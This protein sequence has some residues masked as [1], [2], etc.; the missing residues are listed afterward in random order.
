MCG[1]S[2][3]IGS[4]EDHR[5]AAHKQLRLNQNRRHQGVRRDGIDRVGRLGARKFPDEP[6]LPLRHQIRRGLHH[7]AIHSVVKDFR[8]LRHHVGSDPVAIQVSGGVRPLVLQIYRPL[9]VGLNGVW[10][11][12][13]EAHRGI[14]RRIQYGA[15]LPGDEV[16]EDNSLGGLDIAR[17]LPSA[18]TANGRHRR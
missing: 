15:R 8:P 13:G 17:Q 14:V 10:P 16:R 9:P 3:S 11:H 5:H 1:F 18:A 7:K 12:V 4:P 2:L 6:R